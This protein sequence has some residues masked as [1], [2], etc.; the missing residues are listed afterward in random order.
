MKH[1]VYYVDKK[2]NYKKN[3]ALHISRFSLRARTKNTWYICSF[4]SS[5][6]SWS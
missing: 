6:V 4:V 2:E 5:A 1:G 3:S